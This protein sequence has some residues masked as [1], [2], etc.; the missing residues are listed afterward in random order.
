LQNR[1]YARTGWDR[2]V[3]RLCAEHGIVYQ[4][5]SLL[6][7]NSKE[8]AGPLVRALCEQTGRSPAELVFRFAQDV[9]I[10]P[11]TGTSDAEHM[12]LDLA[13]LELPLQPAHAATLEAAFG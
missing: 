7:A 13:A 8:L 9:G 10:L 4:G 11:L 5:F 2:K 12:R 6:T 3:R 1:C